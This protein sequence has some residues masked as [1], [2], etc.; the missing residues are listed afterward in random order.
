MAKIRVGFGYD[1]HKIQDG[2][3]MT[4]GGVSVPFERGWVAHSDG[5]VLIHAVCDALLGAANMRDIG[6]HFP[7]NSQE[8]AGI[9][10]KRL[11]AQVI[12]IIASKGY[13][14][15][16]V[17]CTIALQRPKIMPLIPLMAQTMA[18]VIGIEPDCVSVKATTTEKLGFEGR[19][20]GGAAYAVALIEKD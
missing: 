3:P 10:S 14:V 5:D 13:K 1:V 2:L 20:E 12:D 17:D 9:D 18:Q 15:S 4:I 16:N 7:D 6:F 8:F 11:L 19:E